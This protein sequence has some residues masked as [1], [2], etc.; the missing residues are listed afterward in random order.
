MTLVG[1]T[2]LSVESIT[3]LATPV[4]AAARATLWVPMMLFRIAAQM[5]SST[6]GTCLWAAA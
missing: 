5:F 1:L 4:A 3:I 6:M 2:A